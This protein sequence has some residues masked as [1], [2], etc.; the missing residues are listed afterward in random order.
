MSDVTFN[1]ASGRFDDLLAAVG[2]KQSGPP[3]LFAMAARRWMKPLP[4]EG[5]TYVATLLR[6][7]D[8]HWLISGRLK[9]GTGFAAVYAPMQWEVTYLPA[10]QT[11]AF[12]AGASEPERG[13]GLVVGSQ[14]VALRVEGTSAVSSIAE[15]SPDLTAAAMDVL[16]REWVASIGRLWVRDPQRSAEW[17]A[18]WSDATWGAP[19]ITIMADAG[20]VVAMSADGGIIEGR[21]P[22]RTGKTR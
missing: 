15:G 20:M 1:H 11:R 14:G 9:Q 22:W 5:V 3:H 10:P 17:R 19:I 13:L 21:A 4:L 2:Q 7:D 16:D 8:S 12:V 18:V 6:L